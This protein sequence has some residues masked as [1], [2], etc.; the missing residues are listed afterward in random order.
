[1]LRA[2]SPCVAGV[3]VCGG[4]G[5]RLGLVLALASLVFPFSA[6]ALGPLNPPAGP[7]A[8]TPGPE[9][10][11][12]LSAVNT[13]GDSQYVYRITQSGSYY[14]TG[15]IEATGSRGGVAI[16][17]DNVTLDLNGFTINGAATTGFPSGVTPANSARRGLVVRN[18]SINNFPGYGIFGNLRESRFEH[19]SFSGNKSGSLELFQAQSCVA[20]HVTVITTTGEVGI[21][22][23]DNSLI[24]SCVVDGAF[25]GI[26][27]GM[28]CIIRSCVAMNQVGTAISI[29]GGLV[30]GCSVSM[31]TGTSSFNNAGIS[32]GTISVVRGCTVRSVAS[33]G[34][35]ISGDGVIEDCVIE[36]CGKGIAS[37]QFSGG[38]VRI[39]G[40]DV[41][42]SMT[43]AI[44]LPSGKHIVVGNRLR[45]N[46]SNLN[47]GPAVV[48]GELVNCGPGPLPAAA[49]NPTANLVW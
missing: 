45:G 18:G 8:P 23:G 6:R 5:L 15:N 35:F 19:L 16:L 14:L 38:R 22:L 33:A 24:E 13:P 37:S 7:I 25:T 30:E 12:P 48:F 10:R 26:N 49:A 40:N 11:T 39:E 3:R 29:G 17:A 1:M 42:D 27:A 31:T 32:A 20:S 44:D 46:T 47:A 4:P 36:N 21:Q 28:N 43:M 34:V 2:C 9:P 41:N